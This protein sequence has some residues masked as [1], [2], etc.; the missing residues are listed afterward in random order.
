[1]RPAGGRTYPELGWSR[2]LTFTPRV[3][4]IRP[5]RPSAAASPRVRRQRSPSRPGLAR[6]LASCGWCWPR[7]RQYHTCG[8]TDSA[9]GPNSGD[10]PR[11]LD[12]SRTIVRPGLHG[13]SGECRSRP[14]RGGP[15]SERRPRRS[16]R[17]DGD[18]GSGSGPTAHLEPGQSTKSYVKHTIS[19][20]PDIDSISHVR[21]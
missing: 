16:L 18:T 20:Y 5:A 13:P 8:L 12:P 7:A 10:G 4:V 17:G 6:A 15:H 19:V 2:S 3:N 9:R 21:K 1:M 11:R 14:A